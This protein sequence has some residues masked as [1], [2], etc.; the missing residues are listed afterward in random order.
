MIEQLIAEVEPDRRLSLATYIISYRHD[1][2]KKQAKQEQQADSSNEPKK[3]SL[4]DDI[5]THCVLDTVLR[6]YEGIVLDSEKVDDIKLIS[7]YLRSSGKDKRVMKLFSEIKDKLGYIRPKKNDDRR[8]EPQLKKD[9]PHLFGSREVSLE[10]E[11]QKASRETST[12]S[13]TEK[14]STPF[15]QPESKPEQ[16]QNSISR[17]NTPVI[18][19]VSKGEPEILMI[20]FQVNLRNVMTLMKLSL[21]AFQF[22]LRRYHLDWNPQRRRFFT[23]PT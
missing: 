11:S 13:T 8:K 20:T 7:M 22:L 21:F 23:Q 1:R 17:D 9:S 14:E 12:Q 15:S 10:L 18:E 16:P 4:E 6:K 2:L 19:S 5:Y 3:V